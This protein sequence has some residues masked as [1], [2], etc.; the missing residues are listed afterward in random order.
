VAFC[1]HD[2]LGQVR[3]PRSELY[4]ALET[5]TAGQWAPLTLVISTQAPTDSDLLSILIDDALTGADPRVVCSLYTTPVDADPFDIAANP[6]IGVY[7]NP[8][9]VLA[10]AAD[11]KRMPAREAAYR[12]LVCNMRVEASAPFITAAAWNA[13]AGAPMD[14]PGRDVFAGLDLSAVSD[15]TALVLVG[16][17]ITLPSEG[18]HDKAKSDRIPYDLWHSQ[19]HLETTPGATISYEYVAQHL[20][21]VF[22]EHRVV[23]HRIR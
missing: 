17:D 19:N 4:E 7:Q 5:A 15:L 13:C 14:L 16:C 6:A 9:E 23:Q 8:D 1:V 3:G 10:M 20:K 11:A 22:D 2:E 18:L 12:N 21:R